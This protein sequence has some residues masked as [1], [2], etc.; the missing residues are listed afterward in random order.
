MH[1]ENDFRF[2][3]ISKNGHFQTT[4]LSRL[5]NLNISFPFQSVKL[6]GLDEKQPII[7]IKWQFN[8]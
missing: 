6:T 3:I 4:N 7:S 8:R 2:S 5:K 1:I